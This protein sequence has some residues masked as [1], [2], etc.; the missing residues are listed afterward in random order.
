MNAQGSSALP[1]HRVFVLA[2][3]AQPPKR[4]R[5][6]HED[7]MV[8][9]LGSTVQGRRRGELVTVTGLL[10]GTR[11]HFRQRTRPDIHFD[12]CPISDAVQTKGA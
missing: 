2:R 1:T 3:P 9:A 6:Q 12:Q 11:Y 5:G 7:P 4:R 8:L 10:P